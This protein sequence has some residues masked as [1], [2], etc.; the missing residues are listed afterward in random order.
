M[1]SRICTHLGVTCSC[2]PSHPLSD[3][4]ISS[5]FPTQSTP[6]D[7]L[8]RVNVQKLDSGRAVSINMRATD[9]TYLM[10]RVFVSVL[11]HR[12]LLSFAFHL[13][14]HWLHIQVPSIRS[15]MAFQNL[16]VLA[17]VLPSSSIACITWSKRMTSSA[18]HGPAWLSAVYESP[19]VVGGIPEQHISR[20]T[21]CLWNW[22][23][24]AETDCSRALLISTQVNCWLMS[25][26][27]R[28]LVWRSLCSI[29]TY[30][31]NLESSRGPG[32][33][34]TK[35]LVQKLG[36]VSYWTNA[37]SWNP[38]CYDGLGFRQSD[39]D[40]I[41]VTHQYFPRIPPDEPCLVQDLP[42]LPH[43]CQLPIRCRKEYSWWLCTHLPFDIDRAPHARIL[44]PQECIHLL[45][46]VF[47]LGDSV[48]R[49][50]H[51]RHYTLY[52][53]KSLP[54]HHFI[55]SFSACS[56]ATL[57]VFPTV[58]ML[59]YSCFLMS[60]WLSYYYYLVWCVQ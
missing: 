58:F 38:A 54:D 13:S 34:V 55:A 39:W 44:F 56:F 40:I 35:G 32:S 52:V 45:D 30:N 4:P 33:L 47:L 41:T 8:L 7:V 37:P 46:M 23:R 36:M 60:M 24:H 43:W 22:L 49:C 48:T 31:F 25:L 50:T 1:R 27:D 53:L 21:R 6:V 3:Q 15:D 5:R 57:F 10:M 42:D 19:L 20:G 29:A 9:H 14:L 26:D 18:V 11:C 2:Q 51:R 17:G 59:W 12:I 16:G 28:Q